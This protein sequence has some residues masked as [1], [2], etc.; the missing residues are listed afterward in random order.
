MHR[1]LPQRT[2]KY[3]V[4]PRLTALVRNTAKYRD[5]PR[6]T[7]AYRLTAKYRDISR[8]TAK[9]R[10]VPR[11]TARYRICICVC[12]FWSLGLLV[13]SNF[14]GTLAGQLGALYNRVA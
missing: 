13:C 6:H 3:R 2:A 12:N 7:A 11:R 9:Y 14:H 10:D 8:H 4:I 5:I 1:T